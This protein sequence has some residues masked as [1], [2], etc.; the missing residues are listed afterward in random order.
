MKLL[1]NIENTAYDTGRG[2]CTEPDDIEKF[3]G[4]LF[5][6]RFWDTREE[7]AVE[8]LVIVQGLDENTIDFQQSNDDGELVGDRY[9]ANIDGNGVMGSL[10]LR[11]EQD[12]HAA[13][14]YLHRYGESLDDELADFL[15]NYENELV[16]VRVT[17]GGEHG[18]LARRELKNS[19][20]YDEENINK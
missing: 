18:E 2:V 4:S 6:A 14:G 9:K 20:N 1:R 7:A 13:E 3:I 8:G 10:T 17:L 15:S 12:I 16:P 19:F 11:D 5:V